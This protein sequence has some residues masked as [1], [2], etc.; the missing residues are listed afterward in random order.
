MARL[1]FC[2]FSCPAPCSAI[3][4]RRPT[5]LLQYLIRKLVIIT[6]IC[7]LCQGAPG[8]GATTCN[9]FPQVRTHTVSMVKKVESLARFTGRHV[10]DEDSPKGSQ[11]DLPC[12]KR[13]KT[14]DWFSSLKTSRADAFCQDSS[15]VREAREHYFATHPW[16]WVQSNMDDLSDIIRELAQ[17]KVCWA[18]PFPKYNDH[19]MDRII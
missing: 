12:S 9:Y 5:F 14:S 3:P 6:S 10:I 11:E 13:E 7:S 4:Q 15:P 17:S 2:P 8:T 19:G 16:D 1:P 18:N